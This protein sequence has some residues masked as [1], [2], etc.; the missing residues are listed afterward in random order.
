MF[1][2]V[3]RLM[4]HPSEQMAMGAAGRAQMLSHTW[5]ELFHNVYRASG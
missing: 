2:H 5:D 4:Q 3:L 1:R